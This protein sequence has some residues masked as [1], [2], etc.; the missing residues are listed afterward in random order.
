MKLLKLSLVGGSI[1]L[2]AVVFFACKKNAEDPSVTSAAKVSK[3]TTPVITCGNATQASIEIQVCAPQGGTGLPAGFSLQWMTKAAYIA[4]GNKWFDDAQLCKASFSGNANLSRYNLTPGQCVT[5]KVGEFLFDE[6]ASTNCGDALNCGT[7]YV[8]RAFGHATSTL[9]RSDFTNPPLSCATLEC[10]ITGECT[11]TQG[12][13]KTH[14]PNVCA[15]NAASPL[16]IQWPASSVTLGTVSYDVT[17]L[18][19]I[20]NTPASGNGLIALAHQ[21]IAA[22]LNIAK[23]ANPTAI[24]QAI[25]DADNLIGGLVVPPVGNGSLPPAAT[26]AL[27]TALT[28]FN[29]GATGPGHCQ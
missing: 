27:I 7:E 5:V 16:C 20:F 28:N 24:A 23:G 6:G 4:N 26:S 29:E 8:F 21:L 11:Y 12:Y 15:T 13:W 22:K 2:A 17:Q 19:S 9:N 3:I 14:N 10:R 18:L 25:I 1:A